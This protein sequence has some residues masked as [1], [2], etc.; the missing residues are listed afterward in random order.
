MLPAGVG[1][2]IV[3][4]KIDFVRS[5]TLKT[6]HVRAEGKVVRVGKQIG[7]SDGIIYDDNGQVLAK[8]SATCLLL[9]PRG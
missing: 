9:R 7:Q 1:F 6:G 5:I 2:T 8:G 3:E 4:V